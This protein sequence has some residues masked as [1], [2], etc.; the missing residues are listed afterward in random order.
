ML[1][2]LAFDGLAF[3]HPSTGPSFAPGRFK[4]EALV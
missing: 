2:A 4:A 1:V 3:E